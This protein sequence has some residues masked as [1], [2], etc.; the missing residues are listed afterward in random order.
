VLY[1]NLLNER[2]VTEVHR[3]GV[4]VGACEWSLSPYGPRHKVVSREQIE[5]VVR[6]IKEEL[7]DQKMSKISAGKTVKQ[8]E[9]VD[10]LIPVFLPLFNH[11]SMFVLIL[12]FRQ[13]NANANVIMN[14]TSTHLLLA[15][16]KL[17]PHVHMDKVL[18]VRTD[19]CYTWREMRVIEA[20]TRKSDTVLTMARRHHTVNNL[21]K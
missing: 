20:Q 19:I 4:E 12:Y 17:I 18:L 15:N 9:S 2:L 13:I 10:P 6:R 21:R 7:N 14:S 11:E 3:L 8:F 1:P 16:S 5:K